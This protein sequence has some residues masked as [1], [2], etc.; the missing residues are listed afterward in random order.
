MKIRRV[1]AIF[2]LLVLLTGLICQPAMASETIVVPVADMFFGSPVR[3]YT[4]EGKTC[5]EYDM[6]YLDSTAILKYIDL[7]ENYFDLKLTNS[8]DIPSEGDYYIDLYYGKVNAVMM[9]WD[10]SRERMSVTIYDRFAKFVEIVA[11]E[12]GPILIESPA[13]F[14]KMD[15]DYE[16]KA[17]DGVYIYEADLGKNG[18]YALANYIKMLKKEYGIVLDEK[19]STE[20]DIVSVYK[21]NTDA[22]EY[23]MAVLT[24]TKGIH[25]YTTFLYDD[26]FCIPI[27]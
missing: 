20:G 4:K 3:E 12:D 24:E 16:Y 1:L 27:D 15:M 18:I 7:L 11:I 22:G 25:Y 13:A 17:E 19:N 5:L 21:F 8:Y 2:L 9:Y 14:F 23:C 26:T 6:P 10:Q